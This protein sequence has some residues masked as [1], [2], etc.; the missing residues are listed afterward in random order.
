M[1]GLDGY[2]PE[3]AE[4]PK[5]SHSLH[6]LKISYLK[7]AGKFPQGSQENNANA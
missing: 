1:E 5:V 3:R 4:F 2:I 6:V 7:S